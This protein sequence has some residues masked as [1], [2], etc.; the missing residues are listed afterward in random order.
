[1]STTQKE[2]ILRWLPIAVTILTNLILVA[3]GYGQLNQRVVPL[4][5]YVAEAPASVV[6]R[7]EFNQRVA[8]RD[9]EMNDMKDRLER[10]DGK[11]DRLLERQTKSND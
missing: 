2:S 8:Y 7:N 6:S 5:K 3:Y 9:R 10:M 4:E 11:L 1:M